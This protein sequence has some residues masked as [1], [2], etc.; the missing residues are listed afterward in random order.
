MRRTSV[1]SIVVLALALVGAPHVGMAQSTNEAAQAVEAF[2]NAMLKADRGQ[3]DALTA[4]QLSYGH[5]GG[6]VETKAQFIDAATNGPSPWKFITLTD[7]TTHIVGDTAIV[8]H[9]LTGETERDGKTTPVKIGVL[10]VWHKQE[11]TWKLLARQAVRLPEA[12][13]N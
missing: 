13:T 5:S 2:R 4:E 8:R 11:G 10:M 9:T 1:L 12:A 6:R 3:F 7:Q